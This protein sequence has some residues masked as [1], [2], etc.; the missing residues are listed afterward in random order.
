MKLL[1]FSRFALLA[2][3]ALPAFAQ[4]PTFTVVNTTSLNATLGNAGKGIFEPQVAGFSGVAYG[5]NLFVAVAASNNETVIRWAT[6]TDGTTWTPRSQP[7]AGGVTA[8]QTSRVHFQN[9]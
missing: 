4:T 1:R 8:A 2:L 9:G 3:V 7:V 5:A 6:S